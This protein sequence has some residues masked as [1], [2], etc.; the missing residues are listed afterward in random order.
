MCKEIILCNYSTYM[1]SQNSL[2]LF[3]QKLQ[4]F[5]EI[6]FSL[7]YLCQTNSK[8]NPSSNFKSK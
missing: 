2:L 7:N 8:K 4:H 5:R 1:R 3:A 6:L